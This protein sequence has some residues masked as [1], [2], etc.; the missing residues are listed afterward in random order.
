MAILQI[1]FILLY[2]A[3]T[4]TSYPPISWS[5]PNHPSLGL[6]H[7]APTLP[8]YLYYPYKCI[9]LDEGNSQA[10]WSKPCFSKKGCS[11]SCFPA[12]FEL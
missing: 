6:K 5:Y 12:S 3:H 2:G 4:V 9:K 8:D 11:G 10:L 1:Q 7:A